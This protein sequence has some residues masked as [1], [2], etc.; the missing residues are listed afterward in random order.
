MLRGIAHIDDS[1]EL[2]SIGTG[3]DRFQQGG[4]EGTDP[5]RG[6]PLVLRGQH[7]VR[8][9]DGGID[10]GPILPVIPPHPRLGRTASNG[11]KQRSAVVGAGGSFDGL[12]GI[13]IGDC[14]YVDGLFV[15]GRGGDSAGFKDAVD[16]LR[17][18]GAGG[19]GAAGVAAV[20]KG[21]EVHGDWYFQ[22]LDIP[23]RCIGVVP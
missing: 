16:G 4:V 22:V 11:Q 18:D 14:P 20:E 6:E 9:D 23:L 19:E 17:G 2:V 5:Q 7:E 13:Q 12:Q 10:L 15:D 21:G 1:D 3:E 8:G